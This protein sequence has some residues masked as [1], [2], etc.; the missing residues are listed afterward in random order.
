MTEI[1]VTPQDQVVAQERMIAPIEIPQDNPFSNSELIDIF[2]IMVTARRLDEKMLNLLKQGKSFFHIGGSGHEAGQIAAARA[3]EPGKDWS[4]PYYRDLTYMLGMG[5]SVEQV[6]INFLARK[7]DVNSGGRQMPQHYGFKDARVVSQSSPTGTQFLQAVGTAKGARL[8]ELDEVVYVSSGEGTTSQGEFHEALN[9]ASRGKLPVI[10][11]IQDNKY[12]ISVHLS[13]Q[14]GGSVY[15]MVAG[16][17]NLE[18][19]EID[20][21]NFFESHSVFKHAADRARRGD[22]PSVIVSDVVRLLPHSSSDDHK[23]YRSPEELE[24]DRYRCPINRLEDALTRNNILSADE[25]TSMREEI[26]NLVNEAT[27]K[28]EALELPDASTATQ[29]LFSPNPPELKYEASTPDGNKTVLVDAVNHALREEMERNENIIVYGQDV[30]DGKGG[31]FTATK[32]L[33]TKFGTQRCFNSPLAEASIVGTA[34]GLSVRGFKP[35]VE[36]QFGD[37]IW[38]A[39]M[40]VRNEAATMRYRSNNE[41]SSPIVIRV[42]VGG[43]IH[44]ALYH[45]QSIEAV[46]AHIPGLYIAFPSNAA[47]AKGLLKTACR[48]DD[49]VLF[50]EHK[51]LYR[52]SHATALEPDSEYLLPFGKA[53]IRREGTDVTVVTWGAIVNKAMESARILSKEGYSVE[54][55]DIRTIVPLD[56]ETI[57]NSIK[58]T[59]KVLIAHEDNLTGGFGAEIAARIASEGFE[60]LDGPIQRVAAKDCHIPYSWNLEPMIL[61]QER[62]VQDAVRSLLEY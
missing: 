1:A 50:L 52:Q 44:G 34:I 56:M 25:A 18:R 12:A 9:W 62:D 59:N 2:R 20:G 42:P 28:A 51:G 38:T 54:V 27:D 53:A 30:E 5:M 40:Q 8:H 48:M 61:P 39:M 49:P 10:F 23:K 14:T 32:G 45:S 21:T 37:Y 11:N 60:H 35:V 17:A 15:D 47:D 26:K 29:F 7:G 24:L 4:Y 46:F 58:K 33:S 55:I 13:Q 6:L 31:V 3:L 43:Y 57:L 36:I 19:H 41:W 22:G 16:Y